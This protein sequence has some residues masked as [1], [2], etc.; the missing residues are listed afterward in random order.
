[1]KTLVAK[2]AAGAL[3]ACASVGLVN[4]QDYPTKPIRFIVP[5]PGGVDAIAR[6]F[7]PHLA[8]ALG[9][10]TVIENLPGG[11]RPGMLVAKAEPDGHTLFLTGRG[12]WL[13]PLTLK[14]APYDSLKDFAAIGIVYDQPY[15]LLVNSKLPVKSVKELIALAKSRPGQ[16]NMGAGAPAGTGTLGGALFRQMAGVDIK[17]IPYKTGS[18]RSAGLLAG[19]IEVDFLSSSETAQLGKTDRVRLI[20]VSSGKPSPQYPGT[21]PIGEAVPGY[22]FGSNG[23]LFAPAKTPARIITRVNQ[24]LN[25]L[26]KRPDI[27]KVLLASGSD[28]VG[29]SVEE[30]T[31]FVANDY[32]AMQKVL[33]AEGVKPQ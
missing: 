12:H 25:K 16:L 2:T 18:D 19:Q 32:Q 29:G 3:L 30:A 5:G 23:I 24:E 4:A 21:L 6:P 7:L 17:A 9:Q 14:D 31:R 8:E 15:L 22:D 11:P 10:T 28:P 27:Q 26:L 33:A 1:M 13:A 20:A